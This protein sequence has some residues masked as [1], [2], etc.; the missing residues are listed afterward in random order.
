MS[1]SRGGPMWDFIKW[2]AVRKARE[3]NEEWLWAEKC[4]V[5]DHMKVAAVVEKSER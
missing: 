5:G 3:R 1:H 2:V 4:N